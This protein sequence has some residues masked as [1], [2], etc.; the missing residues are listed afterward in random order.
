MRAGQQLFCFGLQCPLCVV[1]LN[2]C[3]SQ[4]AL[5]EVG[6]NLTP[7]HLPRSFAEQLCA[8]HALLFRLPWVLLRD[9]CSCTCRRTQRGR[10]RRGAAV[11]RACT[12][13]C[14]AALRDNSRHRHGAQLCGGGSGRTL[15]AAGAAGGRRGRAA[16]AA[17]GDQACGSASV[18]SS[19]AGSPGR[20]RTGG[21]R[22]SANAAGPCAGRGAQR[23]GDSR[24]A[25]ALTTQECPERSV[26]IRSSRRPGIIVATIVGELQMALNGGLVASF[27]TRCP[28][29]CG[30]HL[31]SLYACQGAESCRRALLCRAREHVEAARCNQ[32]RPSQRTTTCL[33]LAPALVGALG[34]A[35]TLHGCLTE[36][37]RRAVTQGA[38]GAST[39]ASAGSGPRTVAPVA[40]DRHYV[41][42]AEARRAVAAAQAASEGRQPNQAPAPPAA[43][44]P[45][46]PRLLPCNPSRSGA[47]SV[48]SGVSV[49]LQP[50]C[51]T[52]GHYAL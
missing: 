36:G 5:L 23:T 43:D 45:Q 50:L 24:H 8:P 11:P 2:L 16:A 32:R 33:H 9:T 39:G 25:G 48:N 47:Q 19:C 51:F 35:I 10:Q 3:G 20:W 6:S 26:E 17:A 42:A 21:R 28:C 7:L 1:V 18:R 46:V 31:G 27:P 12:G 22:Q 38:S 52:S 29:V 30:S 41:T 34:P 40:T 13:R 4:H 14:A 49:L 37:G 44:L 15:G